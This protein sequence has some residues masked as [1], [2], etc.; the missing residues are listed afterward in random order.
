MFSNITRGSCSRVDGIGRYPPQSERPQ[1]S[2]CLITKS[3]TS[4]SHLLREIS[5]R[6]ATVI[7]TFPAGMSSNG[8]SGDEVEEIASVSFKLEKHIVQSNF[9]TLG[10]NGTKT[11]RPARKASAKLVL[12]LKP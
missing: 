11:H 8:L 1:S 10:G 9:S 4:L 3:A 2:F 12:L 7:L 6:G 5:K